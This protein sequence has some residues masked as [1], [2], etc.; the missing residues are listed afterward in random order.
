MVAA[1]GNGFIELMSF[2]RQGENF[3]EN[4]KII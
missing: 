3:S 4:I 2:V 1:I